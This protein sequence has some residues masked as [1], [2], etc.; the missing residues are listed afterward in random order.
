VKQIL[1]KRTIFSKRVLLLPVIF[2]SIVL[3]IACVVVIYLLDLQQQQQQEEKQTP[4]IKDPDS[5]TTLS[6][7]LLTQGLSSPT[8]ISFVD[9]NNLLVLEKNGQVRLISNGILQKQP[10]LTVPVNTTA[11]RGLLGIA[12]AIRSDSDNSI[13]NIISYGGKAKNHNSLI[14]GDV[15]NKKKTI[16]TTSSSNTA[17]SKQVFLYFTESK[18][19][20][21]LRNRVYRYDWNGQKHLLSNPTLLLDLPALPGPYHNGGKMV[22]GPDH[23]LYVIIGSLNTADGVLQNNKHGKGPDDTSVILRINP[24]DGSAAPNNP[25][26]NDATTNPAMQKYY[27]YGI[28]NSFG[29]TFD[30][31]TGYIWDTETGELHYD[32]VNLV[33]PGFNSGWYKVM[34]P[35]SRSNNITIQRDLVNFKGSH[36]SDPAFSWYTKVGVTAIEF[37]KSSKLGQKYTNDVFVGDIN[38]GNLYYFELN[39]TRTGFS[40]DPNTQSGLIDKVADNKAEASQITFATGFGGITD[41]KT[42]PDGFLY[43]LSYGHGRLYRIITAAQRP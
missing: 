11:E 1:I 32:E 7:Q 33:K 35:I 26:I 17:N 37:F 43:I 20:K 34:G 25:F 15:V 38:N 39:K 40:F 23:Y 30:P 13:G 4:T 5:I 21:P 28:R 41:I 22:I 19:G 27:A 9:N 12:T 18:P 29:L 2:L 24:N 8:S 3:G 36:Y 10:I 14:N 16:T 42:G 31:I 6:V